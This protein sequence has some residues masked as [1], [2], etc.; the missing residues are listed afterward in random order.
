MHHNDG[1]GEATTENTYTYDALHRITRADEV[2]GKAW[3]EYQYD[4]LSN[5][6]LEQYGKLYGNGQRSTV[7]QYTCDE[8]NKLVLGVNSSG[9]SSAYLYNG[10]GAL[11]G[12]TRQRIIG[13]APVS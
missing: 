11:V 1:T 9:E 8:T 7:G 13:S 3:R 4:S 6:V 12:L 5:L 10:L 2:Y